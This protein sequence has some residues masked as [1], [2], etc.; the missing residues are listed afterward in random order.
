[1]RNNADHSCNS[2]V[3]CWLVARFGI[4]AIFPILF[5]TH[6]LFFGFTIVAK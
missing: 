6:V 3:G 2:N 1:L 4:V 5:W